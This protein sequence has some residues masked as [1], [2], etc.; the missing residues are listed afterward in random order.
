VQRLLVILAL[1]VL[2]AFGGRA[3]LAQPEDGRVIRVVDG[4]TLHVS[5][6]GQD[7]TVRLIGIDTPELRPAE[8]GARAATEA[9]TELAAGRRV[10]LVGDTSQDERDRYGRRLAYVV[11]GDLDLGEAMLRRGW[12][13]VYVFDRPFERLARYREAA[14]AGTRRGAAA[15]C[16]S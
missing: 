15:R 6:D 16:A 13:E 7:E 4:D 9:M 2:A 12:A 10:E 1:L 11:R 8:C 14:S 5:V 3:V